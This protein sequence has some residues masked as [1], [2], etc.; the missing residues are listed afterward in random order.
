ML[1]TIKK[2]TAGMF[3]EKNA[4]HYRGIEG[5]TKRRHGV[6]P[7]NMKLLYDNHYVLVTNKLVRISIHFTK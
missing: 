5:I 7:C 3:T 2:C 4:C 1:I 6:L